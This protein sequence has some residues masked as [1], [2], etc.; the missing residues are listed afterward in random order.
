M[1]QPLLPVVALAA[2]PAGAERHGEVALPR[3]PAHDRGVALRAHDF[4]YGC[5]TA[6]HC[7]ALHCRERWCSTLLW[8]THQGASSASFGGWFRAGSMSATVWSASMS[9]DRQTECTIGRV[10]GTGVQLWTSSHLVGQRELPEVRDVEQG[11]V[12]AC[13]VHQAAVAAPTLLPTAVGG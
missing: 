2:V 9:V 8:T 10:G 12:E 3:P 6:L 5:A 13:Q 1:E 7:T 11:D 4:H